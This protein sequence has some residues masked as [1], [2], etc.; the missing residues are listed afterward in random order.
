MLKK[1]S[2]KQLLILIFFIAGLLLTTGCVSGDQKTSEPLIIPPDINILRV[3]VT[4]NAPPL[5][6][7]QANKIVGLEAD[8]AKELAKNFEIIGFDLVEVS[9]GLDSP[10]KVTQVCAAKLIAEFMSFIKQLSKK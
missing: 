9:P 6:F 3:G 4:P 8:L 1:L 5:I 2:I 10:N 7:K